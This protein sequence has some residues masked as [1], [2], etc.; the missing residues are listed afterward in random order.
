MKT[1]HSCVKWNPSSL[2]LNP[3]HLIIKRFFFSVFFQLFLHI[4]RRNKNNLQDDKYPACNTILMKNIFYDNIHHQNFEMKYPSNYKMFIHWITVW[5]VWNNE[6]KNQHKT[7]NCFLKPGKVSCTM[8]KRTFTALLLGVGIDV[9]N[10]YKDNK[11]NSFLYVFNTCKCKIIIT[12]FL[13]K[14]NMFSVQFV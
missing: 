9:I 1:C 2:T 11:R 4:Y 13:N 7:M 12:F 8:S 14:L 5:L 6:F 10:A 3:L